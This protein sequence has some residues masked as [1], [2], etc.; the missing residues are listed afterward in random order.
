VPGGRCLLAK[1]PCPGKARRAPSAVRGRER[2]DLARVADGAKWSAAANA[3]HR[4]HPGGDRSRPRDRPLHVDPSSAP[5]VST[6]NTPFAGPCPP[7]RRSA[8]RGLSPPLPAQ[9]PERVP[10]KKRAARARPRSA[11]HRAVTR[12]SHDPAPADQLWL[13]AVI[14]RSALASSVSAR[15]VSIAS[16]PIGQQ[17]ILI[18]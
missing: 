15:I 12:S 6:G 5:S 8:S 1:R 14:T 11:K 7:A 4:A 17:S 9:Q 16:P 10:Q 18:A 3:S 2:S 13:I